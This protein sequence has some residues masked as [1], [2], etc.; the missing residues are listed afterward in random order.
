MSQR[1]LQPDVVTFTAMINGL[2][3]EGKMEEA[4]GLFELMNQGGLQ[5]DVVTFTTLISGLFKVG[6][7]EEANGLLELLS[8]RGLSRISINQKKN[9][10][11]ELITNYCSKN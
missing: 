3:K 9:A 10:T 1:G 5:P 8:Q 7:M 4:N 11:L 2:C 6:K